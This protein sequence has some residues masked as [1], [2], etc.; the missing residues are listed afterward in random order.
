MKSTVIAMGAIVALSGALV[1]T[2]SEVSPVNDLPNP[3]QAAVR[4][5][6][7]PADGRTWGS[8]AGIEIGPKG[9]VWAIDRCGANSCDGSDLPPIHMLDPATGKPLK[10]IGAGLFVF[11]HGLHV[12]KD[13]NVW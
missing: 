2:Q 3:Y 8:T 1:L 5:W 12:D 7:T 9:E 11:P 6:G 10:S 13:G 4:N